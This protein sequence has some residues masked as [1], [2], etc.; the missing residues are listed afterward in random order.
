MGFK[1]VS[2]NKAPIE[3]QIKRANEMVQGMNVEIII[4][5]KITLG[6]WGGVGAD[7]NKN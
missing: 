2:V 6:V 7:A 1:G 5:K 4:E 3:E